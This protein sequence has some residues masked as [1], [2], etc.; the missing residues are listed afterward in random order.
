MSKFKPSFYLSA[1][2]SNKEAEQSQLMSQELSNNFSYEDIL[3][4][5]HVH[6]NSPSSRKQQ[7]T[8]LSK[9]RPK[10]PN[11]SSKTKLESRLNVLQQPMGLIA[12]QQS[13]IPVKTKPSDRPNCSK[14]RS[15]KKR[16]SRSPNNEEQFQA[17]AQMNK[18][19][20][21]YGQDHPFAPLLNKKSLII[22][23]KLRSKPNSS[24]SKCEQAQMESNHNFGSVSVLSERP[25][26]F[27]LAD[28]FHSYNPKKSYVESCDDHQESKA[29]GEDPDCVHMRNIYQQMFR[30]KINKYSEHI[31]WQKHGQLNKP[32]NEILFEDHVLR[33][34]KQQERLTK[35]NEAQEQMIK[36]ECSFQPQINS[37]P[38]QRSD[39]PV[40]E[41]LIYWKHV[42]AEKVEKLRKV[43]QNA[44]STPKLEEHQVDKSR[45]TDLEEDLSFV[46]NPSVSKSIAKHLHRQEMVLKIRQQ[47]EDMTKKYLA[48]RP[49]E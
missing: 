44:T 2:M 21:K 1:Y 26:N 6:R 23:S 34:K 48:L 49:D 3:E 30:P 40:E 32:R 13:K 18:P 41:R 35:F 12:K 38:N 15:E 7:P 8:P 5:R 25:T 24:V 33:V 46:N 19:N 20:S 45:H 11:Q 10:S 47:R 16:V 17:K 36:Q 22:A 14:D 29:T 31:D 42:R 43:L 9:A 4:R 39:Y 37:S 28:N 27:D